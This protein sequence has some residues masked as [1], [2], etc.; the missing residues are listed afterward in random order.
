MLLIA[1]LFELKE[2]NKINI[3]ISSMIPPHPTKYFL[4][5]DHPRID[6][7]FGYYI[8]FFEYYFG[9][10]I[11]YIDQFHKLPKVLL[12]RLDRQDIQDI[13]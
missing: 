1:S 6:L 7:R 5:K 11:Q 4:E 13:R 2:A 3:I 12:P 9:Y 8:Q 10:Y